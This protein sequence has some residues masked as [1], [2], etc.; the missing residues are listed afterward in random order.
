SIIMLP[1]GHRTRDGKLLP[2]MRGPF[3]LALKTKTDI[4][5]MA[6]IGAYDIKKVTHWLVKPGTITLVFGD[7]I[8]YQDFKQMNSKQLKEFVK[9]QIQ[10]LID[11]HSASA[12]ER[13]IFDG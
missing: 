9:N 1:E 4:V 3:M 12:K 10:R 6:M 11:N 5:P 8:R 2:F 7:I 13:M